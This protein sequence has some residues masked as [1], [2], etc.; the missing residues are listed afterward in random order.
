MTSL[1]NGFSVEH[2]KTHLL[3]EQIQDAFSPETSGNIYGW[4]PLFT[5]AL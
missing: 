3:L 5:E 1:L 4:V 2:L